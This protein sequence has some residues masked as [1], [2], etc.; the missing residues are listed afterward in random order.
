M[1]HTDTHTHSD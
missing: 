1:P